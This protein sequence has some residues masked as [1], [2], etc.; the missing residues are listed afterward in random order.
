M[1]DSNIKHEPSKLN[2]VIFKLCLLTPTTIK[3]IDLLI[4]FIVSKHHIYKT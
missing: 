1:K 4:D 2:I 3:Y